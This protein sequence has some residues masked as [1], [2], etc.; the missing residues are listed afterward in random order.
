MSKL[1]KEVSYIVNIYEIFTS[2]YLLQ[3]EGFIQ[4][5]NGTSTQVTAMHVSS[6]QKDCNTYLK[7]A[8]YVHNTSMSE[9]AGD[10]PFFLTYGDEPIKIPDVFFTM[11]Q[12]L[13]ITT[14]RK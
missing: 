3:C 6:N 11:H 10:T 2:S 14:E 13:S 7:F 9:N 1:M 12:G 4:P 8:V 5:T